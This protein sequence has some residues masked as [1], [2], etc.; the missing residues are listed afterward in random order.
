MSNIVI[1]KS[2]IFIGNSV[3]TEISLLSKPFINFLPIF[4]Q[5]QLNFFYY[6]LIQI[7][8]YTKICN[9]GNFLRE[10]EN[11]TWFFKK[12]IS[13]NY[14][15]IICANAWKLQSMEIIT[16]NRILRS[17]S[18]LGVIMKYAL[19]YDFCSVSVLSIYRAVISKHFTVFNVYSCD[20]GGCFE[21][22]CLSFLSVNQ[23]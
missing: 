12:R 21:S 7:I 6:T 22:L 3:Q 14:I 19:C 2:G 23:G 20:V 16:E 10:E 4:S 18:N 1:S 8:F 17:S 9:F 5:R 13:H 15:L 11:L